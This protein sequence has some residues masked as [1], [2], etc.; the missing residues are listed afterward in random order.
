MGQGYPARQYYPG[1][2]AVSAVSGK[3][4]INMK[5]RFQIA[6][7]NFHLNSAGFRC[8]ITESKAKK[9][10]DTV[11]IGRTHSVHAEPVTFGLK[12]ALMFEETKRNLMRFPE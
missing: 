11:C 8:Y 12:M 9:Y 10:K 4:R 2:V 6:D 7:V 5:L 1:M 3:G